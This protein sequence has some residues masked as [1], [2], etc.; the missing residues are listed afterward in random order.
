MTVPAMQEMA[1]DNLD[2]ADI[3]HAVLNG[4][5]RRIQGGNKYVIEGLATD[6]VTRVEGGH[7]LV[8]L[9]PA[10]GKARMGVETCHE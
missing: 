4:R 3:E 2:I 1:E 10:R 9:P 8:F 7:P 6:G 5:V